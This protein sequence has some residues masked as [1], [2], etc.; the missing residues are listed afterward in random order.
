[1]LAY[2]ARRLLLAIPVLLVISFVIFCLLTLAPNDPLGDLPLTIPPE[3]RADMRASLGLDQPFFVR[4]LLWLHQF[5]VNE[6]MNL[7]Q[8]LTGYDF[9]DA[10]RTRV[11]SWTT[12]SPVVDL[13]RAAAAADPMGRR[14]RLS[15]RRAARHTH[16]R[17]VGRSAALVVRPDRRLR[18]DGGL[19]DADVLH[20]PSC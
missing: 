7:L 19:L 15:V 3:V 14:P 17:L 20:R 13:I 10:H 11:L 1:M 2:T 12:R 5:F 8:S 9:G 16:R 6:P 18:R 4:F